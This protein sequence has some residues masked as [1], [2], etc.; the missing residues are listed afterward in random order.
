MHI[1]SA[2]NALGRPAYRAHG[3]VRRTHNGMMVSH[4]FENATQAVRQMT[5]GER[6]EST[7]L[8][9]SAFSIWSAPC[10]ITP[11]SAHLKL[12]MIIIAL[13]E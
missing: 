1:T 6:I 5:P 10:D 8:S 13:S 9:F 7:H 2:S 11:S 12:M 4:G 3:T